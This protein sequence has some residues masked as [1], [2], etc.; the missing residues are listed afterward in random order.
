MKHS[1]RPGPAMKPDLRDRSLPT[2]TEDEAVLLHRVAQGDRHAFELFYRLYYRRLTRFLQQVMRRQHLVEEVV[3][4]TMLVVWRKADGFNH[5]SRVSTWI[6]AIA[7]RKALKALKRAHRHGE[8]PWDGEEGY[9]EGPESELI[10]REVQHRL[11]R[12]LAALS[13]E[14]RAVVELTYYHGYA[15]RE[16]AQIVGCPVDT[17]KTRMFHARRKLKVLLGGAREKAL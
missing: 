4:D 7:Y 8:I 17:V 10:E 5:A 12:A 16:I 15:Y 14:H 1:L 3:D 6:F 13:A 2:S 11:R 9:A